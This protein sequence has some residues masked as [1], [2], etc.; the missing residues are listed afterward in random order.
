MLFMP[1]R[2]LLGLILFVGLGFSTIVERLCGMKAA[3]ILRNYSFSVRP[4]MGILTRKDGFPFDPGAKSCLFG[5]IVCLWYKRVD[6][7]V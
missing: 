1:D 6:G 2:I 7:P 4:T 5:A 3:Y